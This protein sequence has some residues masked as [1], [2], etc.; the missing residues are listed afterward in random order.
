MKKNILILVLVVAFAITIFYIYQEKRS[1]SAKVDAKSE[2]K[3]QLYTCPMHPQIISEKPGNCPICGMQLVPMQDVSKGGSGD[4][5]P[6]G[7]SKVF[8]PKETERALGVNYEKVDFRDFK[9]EIKTSGIIQPDETRQHKVTTKFTGWVEEL[10]VNKTGQFVKKGEPLLKIYSPE[11]LVAQQ[12]YLSAIK[13]YER[14]TNNSY[15]GNK[16]LWKELKQSAREKLRLFDLTDKQIEHLEK[17]G[18]AEKTVTVFSPASGFVMEK[19]VIKGQRVMMNEP[20]MNITDLSTVWAE[21]DVYQPDLPFVKIGMPITFTLSYWPG[22]FFN[23]KV[24]FIYPFLNSETRTL[25]IRCEIPNP[26][27]TLKPQMYAEAVLKYNYGKKLAV[28]ESAVI[29]T[30]ER[31]YVFVKDEENHLKPVVIKTGF[32]STDGYFEVLEG[33]NKDQEVVTSA[34]FLI[35]SESSLKAALQAATG[36]HA[37]HQK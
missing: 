7:L 26:N 8:L 27:L 17:T 25:K 30:G 3:K 34:N 22:K 18:I 14:F 21:A 23:G 33:L 12:E 16:D 20:L 31:E 4:K 32:R 24:I 9:K 10:Y 5:T 2:V 11:L 37:G 1:T 15:E 36:E 19:M 13:A 28:P 6:E 35:D 29:R